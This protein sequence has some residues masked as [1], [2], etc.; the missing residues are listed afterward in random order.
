MTKLYHKEIGLP[1]I[2]K[3]LINRQ[4]KLC[5]S[6]HAKHACINDRYGIINKP[7]FNLI[8]NENNII[9]AELNELGGIVKI[10]VRL[11]YDVRFDIAL[12][13]IPDFDIAIVKTVWLNEKNDG[14]KTLDKNNYEKIV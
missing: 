5:Y 4:F 7:P 10:V 6:P 2:V 13:I 14:H 11:P 9:E 12:A 8:L 3:N 1:P